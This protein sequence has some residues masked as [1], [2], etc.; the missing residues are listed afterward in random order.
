MKKKIYLFLVIMSLLLTSGCRKL[1]V[2]DK[3][4]I[5]VITKAT[6]T[7]FWRAV[8][9]GCDTAASEYN[10][11]LVFEGPSN[12]EDYL[13]QVRMI[14]EAIER[15]TGAIVLSAI[16]RE[17]LLPAVEKAAA[18]GIYIVIIDSGIN[19][20]IPEV[21]ISTDNYASGRQA[22][23]AM[24]K[25][26]AEPLNIGVVNFAQGTANGQE[27]EQGFVDTIEQSEDAK[28]IGKVYVDSNLESAK[29]GTEELV[30]KYPE[31]NA[32]ISFNE[33]TTLGA[34]SA[35][36]ELNLGEEIRMIGFDNNSTAIELL[37]DGVIDALL[38]QNQF[39]I[40]YL[41]VECAYNL[42]TEKFI[43][44]REIYTDTTVVE[45]ENLFDESIQKIVF[46]LEKHE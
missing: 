17:K 9:N 28:I 14:D 20:K 38:V 19:G 5:T 7:D 31:L 30:E 29:T 4:Q 42:I 23:E 11:N 25:G 36:A 46:P 40:G 16:D 21:I 1:W 32:V 2:H 12:E 34:G 41:G 35:L 24:L 15:E 33:Y 22:A 27:R 45:L 10:V 13:T 26:A 44:E 18:R 39:A 3:I 6:E 43:A 8:R 37:E